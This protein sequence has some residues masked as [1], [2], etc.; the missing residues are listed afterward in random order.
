MNN[1]NDVVKQ[2]IAKSIINMH[3]ESKMIS[4]KLSVERGINEFLN[5]IPL[6]N[7]FNIILYTLYL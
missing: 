4:N 3:D 1:L 2:I 6:F 5:K 7:D